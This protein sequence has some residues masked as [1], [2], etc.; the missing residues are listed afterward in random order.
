MDND[1]R[2]KEQKVVNLTANSKQKCLQRCYD[3]T[4]SDGK[5]C[6]SCRTIAYLVETYLYHHQGAEA[7]T[8]PIEELTKA[9]WNL[10]YA[11]TRLQH[12][13][14]QAPHP[15]K[16]EAIKT[17]HTLLKQL[18]HLNCNLKR[19]DSHPLS[20]LLAMIVKDTE[21]MLRHKTA[22]SGGMLHEV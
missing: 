13:I 18:A 9:I 8:P 14:Q 10:H 15:L 1:R 6:E 12:H 2:T 16:P 20:F 4:K 3:C 11:K 22:L 7:Q 19:L 5:S 17:I 21:L